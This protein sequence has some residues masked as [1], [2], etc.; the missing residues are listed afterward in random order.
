ML[1]ELSEKE[2]KV[3][4]EDIICDLESIHDG[5]LNCYNPNRCE[6]IFEGTYL[7]FIKGEHFFENCPLS[8]FSLDEGVDVESC[9]SVLKKLRKVFSKWV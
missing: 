7:L 3:I 8:H 4:V 6:D 2:A 5:Q 1:I 9:Q